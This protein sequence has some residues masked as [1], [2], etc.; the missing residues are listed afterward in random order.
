[1]EIL[2]EKIHLWL[3]SARFVKAKAG[4][5][6]LYD[7]KLDPIYIG[8]SDNLQNEFSRYLDTNFDN[9]PCKQKTHTYQRSFTANPVEKKKLLLDEFVAKTGALPSCNIGAD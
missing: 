6:I 7:K 8:A 2:E 3:D 4:V 9:D 5:Y 1:M